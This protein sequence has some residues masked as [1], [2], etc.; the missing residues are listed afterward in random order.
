MKISIVLFLFIFSILFIVSDSFAETENNIIITDK[1]LYNFNDLVIVV[2]GILEPSI[3]G[4]AS[5]DYGKIIGFTVKDP[6]N[7]SIDMLGLWT[8][9]NREGEF[10]IE[11][12]TNEL[13][14]VLNGDDVMSD[15]G[16]YTV[17]TDVGNY[18]HLE[19]KFQFGDSFIDIQTDKKFYDV[20]DI[21]LVTGKSHSVETV[22]D[23]EIINPDGDVSM[24]RIITPDIYGD[25]KTVF[26]VNSFIH[27][28]NG[29]YSIN[30][31]NTSFDYESKTFGIYGVEEI[32]ET[33]K[34]EKTIHHE[35]VDLVKIKNENQIIANLKMQN[36]I[37][38]NQNELLLVQIATLQNTID[39]QLEII[40]NMFSTEK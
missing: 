20:Y 1:K 37:L 39:N 33:K 30:V 7:D 25:F 32:Q 16:F 34:P 38:K 12:K 36:E 19:T 11:L 18:R 29:I 22:Y 9:V 23:I 26:E 15:E 27:L 40:M 10:R 31:N 35:N 4:K 3:D 17:S 28:V 6:E 24:S 5:T 13:S 21:M 8:A 14:L 2:S